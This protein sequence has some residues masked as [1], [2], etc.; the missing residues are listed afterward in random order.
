MDHLY[1]LRALV[2]RHGGEGPT[3]TAVGGLTLYVETDLSVVT[4]V[5][6]RP[7]LAL[8]LGGAK[9]TVLGGRLFDIVPGDYVAVSVD[10]PATG[11]VTQAPYSAVTLD[12]DLGMLA[13]LIAEPM[14]PQGGAAGVEVNHAGPDLLDAMWRLVRL[15]D[16]PE[17][18]AVLA[19]MIRREVFWRILQSPCGPMVRQIAMADSRLSQVS[20]AITWLR[21][22]FSESVRV[23][24]LAALAGMSP[25]SFHR[26]FKAATAMS[27]L[28]YQ[29]Q[30]RLQTARARLL[31]QQGDVAG[32][33]F[34]VGYES[35]SQFS[36]E[37]ARQFGVSPARDMA[38]FHGAGERAHCVAD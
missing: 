17:D 4:Y 27:P 24:R 15:L 33:G 6:H 7:V 28:Q 36:R 23:E 35:P 34:S 12:L 22:N 26:H 5:V 9:R 2:E 3:E 8:I 31:A 1:E 32:V 16:R 30:I 14:A 29:K 25:V 10:L 21:T 18:I 11:Q 19:P 38:R 20:R 13:S 37:Y